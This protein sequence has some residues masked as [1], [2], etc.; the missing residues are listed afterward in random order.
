MTKETKYGVI[1][2]VHRDSRIVAPAIE[3]LKRKG[4]EKLI[5]NG[6][7]G[8]SPEFVA[9]VLN[10]AGQSGLE[11][12]VQPGSHEKLD[13][14][15]PVM[16]YFKEKY[17]NLV[18]AIEQ[19]K[20]ESD[21]HDIVFLP[22]TDWYCGGQYL[23]DNGE[24]ESGFYERKNNG[25]KSEVVRVSNMNDLRQLVTRPDKT[26]VV[27]HIPRRF[28]NIDTCVDMAE[29]GE[30]EKTFFADI[31]HYRDGE[32]Q[33]RIYYE[34]GLQG[35]ILKPKE[36]E[37]GVR[38]QIFEDGS[39]LPLQTAKSF[40]QAGAPVKIKRENRGNPY[41]KKLYEEIGVNK[42]VSGH[43][44]ESSHRANDR[45]GNHVN[46]GEFVD[47]LFWNS[48]YLDIGHTGILTVKDGKVSYQNINLQEEEK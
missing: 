12:Y 14:F 9:N 21:G 8:N 36:V 31:V 20:V 32:Q 48:G 3:A 15:E 45:A 18:N 1:S 39:V 22:G 29:F 41:L 19:R 35:L 40:S 10:I 16:K 13:D 47:E 43:F 28:D 37:S 34:N 11:S 17:S 4:A 27:C 7:I 42:A 46:Q 26:I 38:N 6:D 30:V 24:L 33:I 44:H 25:G 5:L 2:D 23:L